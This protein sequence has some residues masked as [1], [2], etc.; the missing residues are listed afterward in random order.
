MPNQKRVRELVPAQFRSFVDKI[1]AFQ[2]LAKEMRR[3]QHGVLEK[4]QALE[5]DDQ[6]QQRRDIAQQEENAA[7]EFFIA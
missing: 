4:I 5:H 2:I 7:G 1:S 6:N 3:P